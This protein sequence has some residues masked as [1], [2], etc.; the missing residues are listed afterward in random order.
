MSHTTSHSTQFCCNLLQPAMFFKKFVLTPYKR[1]TLPLPSQLSTIPFS[2]LHNFKQF[3]PNHHATTR[4]DHVHV[5][6]IFFSFIFIIKNLC[7]FFVNYCYNPI[8]NVN[9]SIWKYVKTKHDHF[10]RLKRGFYLKYISRRQPFEFK[11]ENFQPKF[12]LVI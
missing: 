5:W 9:Y 8:R 10:V 3:F 11:V 2:P 7:F 1:S 6:Y 4:F 12:F